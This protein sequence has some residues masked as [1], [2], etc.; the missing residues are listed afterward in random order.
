MRSHFF[1]MFGYDSKLKLK[2]LLLFIADQELAIE[3][4]R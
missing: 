2:E 4:M 3:K 1:Q